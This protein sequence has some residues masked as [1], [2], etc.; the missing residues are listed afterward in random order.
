ME[1]IVTVGGK[2]YKLTTD[3]PL[4]ALERQQTIAQIQKQTGCSSCGPRALSAG[5]GEAFS[6]VETGGTGTC[7]GTAKKSGDTITLAATPLGGVAPYAVRF[8]RMP[9]AAGAMTYGEVGLV[10]T[11]IAEGGSTSDSFVLN[12]ADM[13][14]AVGKPTAGYPVTDTTAGITDPVGSTTPLADN[15]IRVAS[16]IYDSCPVTPMTCVAYCDIALACV[17][18]TCNF[19]VT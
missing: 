7:T 9:D 1:E 17:A 11:G 2:Q 12:D 6:L 13:V 8:W 14:A 4:T 3:R 10:R 5:F 16:T 18:P 15:S 19:V